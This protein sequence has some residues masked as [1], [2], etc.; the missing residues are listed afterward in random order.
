MG[1]AKAEPGPTQRLDDMLS[2]MRQNVA[3]RAQGTGPSVEL[4]TPKLVDGEERSCDD[5]KGE[6]GEEGG[7]K[8][9]IASVFLKDGNEVDRH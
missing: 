4:E 9:S 1:R 2:Q 6:E 5:V 7:Q 8:G 3:K